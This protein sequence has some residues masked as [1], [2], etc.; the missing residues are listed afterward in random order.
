M[1]NVRYLVI[2]GLLI[3][4]LMAAQFASA[5]TVDEVIEKYMD[6]LGGAYRLAAVKSLYMEGIGQSTTQQTI[7]ITK[8]QGK[9]S[10]TIIEQDGLVSIVEITDTKCWRMFPQRISI[11]EITPDENLWILKSEMDIAGPLVYYTAKGHKAEMI[12]KEK[13]DGNTCYKI[14]LITKDDNKM[15]FWIDAATFLL[16]QSCFD[17]PP[18]ERS[19]NTIEFKDYKP[20][21]GIL[22]A[23]TRLTKRLQENIE[24]SEIEQVYWHFILVNP[25]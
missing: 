7:K 16:T 20:V 21:D 13:L 18:G 9:L 22:F 10:R 14:R 6:A 19:G 2:F 17:A 24:M 23:H 1:E 12:G 15:L 3:I 11:E 8:V 5:K 25:F 4:L